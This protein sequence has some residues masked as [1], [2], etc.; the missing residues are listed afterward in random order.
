[1]RN[2]AYMLLV[3]VA[4]A[5]LC[6]NQAQAQ[7]PWTKDV[8]NPVLSGDGPGS[9]NY[10]LL[11]PFVLFNSDS[12]RYEMWFAANAGGIPWK[13]GFATSEDGATWNMYPS[14]V[15]SPD[16][17]TWDQ[18]M[19]IAPCVILENHQYKMWYSAFASATGPSYI[20]CATSQDGIH[21]TKSPSNPVLGPGTMAWELAG[22]L[23]CSVMLDP[24]GYK[25]WY[26]AWKAMD[27]TARIG[28]ATSADGL[29]WQ[30][31]T[32][33]NPVFNVGAPGQWDARV[34]G[35]PVVHFIQNKYFMWY[36]GQ[37]VPEAAFKSAGLAT[38]LDGVNWT[39]DT[40]NPI[41]TTTPGSWDSSFAEFTTVVLRGDTLHAWYDGTSGSAPF[42]IGHA[43]APAPISSVDGEKGDLPGVFMLAQ[44]YPN[45]FNPST[46]IRYQLPRA[47]DVRL[48]IYNLLGREV[49]VLV[50]GEEAPGTY[51]VFFDASHLASGMYLYRLQ[52]GDF[53][54]TRKMIVIK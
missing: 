26:V 31:D 43:T 9:W 4:C 49:A 1:M 46:A 36:Q 22:P 15:L 6:G 28:Y 10:N 29:G 5:S 38:S 34:V 14:P 50:N 12:S 24:S 52:A 39:R 3:F 8:R 41:F 11:N 32:V 25:L 30:K 19:L 20:G 13:I 17:G 40:L 23:Q 35:W 54:Q 51:E 47:N 21:W 48:V 42:R 53:V 27:D 37:K 2:L 7:Y 44:N 45:P 16:P 33:H 18:F